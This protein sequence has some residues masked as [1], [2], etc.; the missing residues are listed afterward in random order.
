M[1]RVLVCDDERHIVRLIQVNLERQ[2][3]EVETC[4]TPE[5]CLHR[6]RSESFELLVVDADM[7]EL[8]H[9]VEHEFVGRIQ[10]MKLAKPKT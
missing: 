1:A 8:I 6:L 4:S 3:F 2:D 7:S 10:V 9:L 5:E